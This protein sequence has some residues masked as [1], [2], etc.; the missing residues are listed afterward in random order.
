VPLAEISQ[1]HHM[2]VYLC[3]G[4]FDNATLNFVG[5][6]HGNA[7]RA[8]SRCNFQRPIAGWAVGGLTNWMPADFGLAIGEDDDHRYVLFELH[9]DVIDSTKDTVTNAGIR[10]HL[11]SQL[12]ES[13]GN[14]ITFGANVDSWLVTPPNTI[15][16]RRGYCV[17]ECT[18]A[19]I[20]AG[21]MQIY[22]T[23]L[24]AH[25][26]GV[27][28]HV[29]HIDQ[30]GTELAPIASDQ[31][32][33]FN[34]QQWTWLEAPR[35]FKRGDQAITTCT[36]NTTGRTKVT[37]GGESTSDEMCLVYALVY[38]RRQTRSTCR[39]ASRPAPPAA[40]R[41]AARSAT[42]S[43]A[44][45]PRPT[46]TS[47]PTLRGVT[48]W[49]NFNRVYDN[50]MSN[51]LDQATVQPMCGLTSGQFAFGAERPAVCK[52][53]VAYVPPAEVCTRV[54]TA[55]TVASSTTTGGSTTTA[56]TVAASGSDTTSTGAAS[57]S[58]T[59]SSTGGSDSTAIAGGSDSTTGGAQDTTALDTDAASTL[60][61]SA[62][63]AL[64]VAL[65]IF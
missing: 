29:Q 36:Y 34:L 17:S 37:L 9:L 2:L 63:L 59:A 51:S 61:A 5:S 19:T 21:D 6:S 43:I 54:T 56:S 39:S 11:T 49:S 23:M 12:R 26:A 58:D 3:H 53:T 42:P 24:H 41:A 47:T 62:T 46:P 45:R 64:V 31:H 27:K 8:L 14:I 65:T 60:V 4:A 25:T 52:P 33:D 55:S 30:N 10:F 28:I 1:T 16:E 40:Y 44:R 20:P 38:A 32:Y 22:A 35:T 15:A 50:V 18:N 57:G 48:D 13:D 7:P